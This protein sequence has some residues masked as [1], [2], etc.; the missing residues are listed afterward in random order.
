MS[1]RTP[2]IA[3]NWKMHKTRTETQ[4]LVR[5]LVEGLRSRPAACEVIVAPPFVSI[6]DAIEGAKGAPIS[7]SGQNMHWEDHG[8]FTGEISASM[9]K[10]A[11][12]S[13]VIIGHSERRR[14]FGET[15]ET[16]NRKIK[17]AT[18]T[19]LIPIFCLGESLTQRE[20]GATFE[21]VKMQLAR[22]LGGITMWDASL[23]V[24]AYEP[25]W[26]IGTGQTAS[27]EQ[28]QEVH[29]FLRRELISVVGSERAGEVRIV[30][31]GSVKPDNSRSL[32]ACED[33]DGFLVGGASL[34]S[35]DFLGII[36]GAV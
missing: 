13:H 12:C 17:A 22:G 23:F 27:P 10:E 34:K 35:V 21:V 30:Y 36:R 32:M 3:G 29:E 6:V 9:L 31:G 28:A 2:I 20:T 26:A 24:I 33:I 8:A 4:A 5:E 11:G 25:V 16:V 18:K 14:F 15:D 7:V 19:E 1:E